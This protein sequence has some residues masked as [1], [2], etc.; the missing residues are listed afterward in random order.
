M[1]H[2]TYYSS[3]GR[4]KTKQL[5]SGIVAILNLKVRCVSYPHR[6]KFVSVEVGQSQSPNIRAHFLKVKRESLYNAFYRHLS[7][8]GKSINSYVIL[9]YWIEYYDKRN[10]PKTS[11][12][13]IKS[14]N[15]RR[16][17]TKI[18]YLEGRRYEKTY[19]K[20]RRFSVTYYN[21]KII[22]REK[23]TRIYD[24]NLQRE[25]GIISSTGE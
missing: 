15:Y 13:M 5:V 9:D 1:R 22:N 2:K 20:R 10:Y 17:Y 12:F 4:Y 19:Y 24:K 23:Y 7:K 8:G 16:R 6:R 18:Q 11:H 25:E 21:D 14:K 3:T